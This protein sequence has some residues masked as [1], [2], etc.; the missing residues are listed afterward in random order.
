[1]QAMRKLY[2]ARVWDRSKEGTEPSERDAPT[3]FLRPNRAPTHRQDSPCQCWS[4]HR[5]KQE[6]ASPDHDPAGQACEDGKEA[7]AAWRPVPQLTR[8]VKHA[9]DASADHCQRPADQNSADDENDGHD[10]QR[11]D[12][13]AA[14]V[15]AAD[16]RL[17]RIVEH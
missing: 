13:K 5:P 15:A 3:I 7:T 2:L 17:R 8:P 16:V 9:R 1:M 4:E 6:Q 10:L 11:A 14:P 12:L